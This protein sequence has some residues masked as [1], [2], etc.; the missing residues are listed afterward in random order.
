[1]L[2]ALNGCCG[3]ITGPVLGP[4]TL[5][6][7]TAF[8]YGTVGIPTAALPTD[9]FNIPLSFAIA[10]QIVPPQ[11]C[12]VSPDIYVATTYNLAAD[13]LINFAPD[14]PNATPPNDTYFA[15]LRKKFGI[16][17]FRA[18]VVNTAHDV[19]TGAGL[20]VPDW[21]QSLT[22]LDLSMLNTVYGRTAMGYMQ[23]IGSLWGLS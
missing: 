13:R 23:Q 8:L 14:Q 6:G 2:P 9:S 15:D 12:W 20:T 7:Y 17:Q 4:A 5:A 1:M 18:G 21:A 10:Q 16:N 22:I 11:M 19:S 3:P